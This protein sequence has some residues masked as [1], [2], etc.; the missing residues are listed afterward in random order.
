MKLVDWTGDWNGLDWITGL[1]YWIG[2]LH[3]AC[4]IRRF[5]AV[6]E[7]VGCNRRVVHRNTRQ[8]DCFRRNAT[9]LIY[10]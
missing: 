5:V 3:C 10:T 9:I 7:G 2:L 4:A 6:G 1:D 8:S